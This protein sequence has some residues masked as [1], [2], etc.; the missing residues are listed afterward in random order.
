MM[1]ALTGIYFNVILAWALYYLFASFTSELPWAHCNN[2][3]NTVGERERE[4]FCS[5]SA[6]VM[7]PKVKKIIISRQTVYP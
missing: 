2:D 7:L 1:S 3:F 6:L 5:I 4:K